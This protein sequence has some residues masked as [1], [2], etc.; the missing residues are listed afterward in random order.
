[1]SS[2]TCGNTEGIFYHWRCKQIKPR[3]CIFSKIGSW[4]LNFLKFV[5][6]FSSLDF[7]SLSSLFHKGG[8]YFYLCPRVPS[9]LTFRRCSFD[10]PGLSVQ[11]RKGCMHRCRADVCMDVGIDVTP[12]HWGSQQ[13]HCHGTVRLLSQHSLGS[14]FSYIPQSETLIKK[15]PQL[16]QWVRCCKVLIFWWRKCVMFRWDFLPVCTCCPCALRRG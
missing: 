6:E 10:S 13:Q 2:L 14:C 5:V 7:F 9:H 12:W 15:S 11:F 3:D 16:L 4:D 8:T 1:M